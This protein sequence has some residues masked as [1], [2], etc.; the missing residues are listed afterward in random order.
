MWWPGVTCFN[1]VGMLRVL[2]KQSTS[3]IR[4]SAGDYSKDTSHQL[5]DVKGHLKTKPHRHSRRVFKTAQLCRLHILS[6]AGYA[7]EW[8]NGDIQ[9]ER[10][11]K[12]NHK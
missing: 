1:G 3:H 12:T 10:E 9:T 5:D 6:L 11:K 2:A 7:R 8:N 4:T